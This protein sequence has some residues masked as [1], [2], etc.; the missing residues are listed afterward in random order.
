MRDE[1]H[2]GSMFGGVSAPTPDAVR[3]KPLVRAITFYQCDAC[4][5]PRRSLRRREAHESYFSKEHYE[6][7]C[8]CGSNVYTYMAMPVEQCTPE[9]L[10]VLRECE[11]SQF[12]D[13]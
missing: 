7:Q 8:P 2:M 12:A 13:A 9:L 4:K 6:S 10:D 5:R 3:G 1:E 11:P